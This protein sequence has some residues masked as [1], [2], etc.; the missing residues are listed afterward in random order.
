[1]PHA[2]G[3]KITRFMDKHGISGW[4]QL[5]ERANSD[6]CWYWDAANEDLGIEWFRRYDK[7]LE[8]SAGIPWT[9]WFINGRCN[10]VANA[11]DRHAKN[12]PDKIAYIFANKRGSKKITYREPDEQVS[13]LAGALV[14]AGIKKCD[15]VSIYLPMIPEAFYAIFACSKIGAVHTTIFS[16]F[17][18]RRYT[19][20]S[21][22][23]M[24]S[25]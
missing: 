10:I 18:L 24:R 19:P 5:V 22:I 3:S 4:R 13:R 7:T 6:I 8:S 1:M 14:A 20:G 21:S 16:G 9:K 25:C 11:I 23:Q 12:Q 15:I 2:A 17:L